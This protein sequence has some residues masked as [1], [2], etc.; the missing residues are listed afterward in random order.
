MK[1]LGNRWVRRGAVAVIAAAGVAAV[2]AR[3]LAHAWEN[4]QRAR[5]HRQLLDAYSRMQRQSDDEAPHFT[6]PS[7]ERAGGVEADDPTIR[8]L[9]TLAYF[10]NQ[11]LPDV[12]Q[13]RFLAAQREST[14]WAALL[15]NA[16]QRRSGAF[17][18]AAVVGQSWVN[19]GPTDARIQ[20][21]GGNYNGIDSGRGARILVDPRDKNI[22]YF[23]TAW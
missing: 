21:N 8:R 13:Q 12:S 6:I 11:A 23:A 16:Q 18:N 19:L 15:P 17:A 3:P 20:A 5:W 7:D 14:R 2:G 4:Y 9:Y 1:L 22:V 10:G